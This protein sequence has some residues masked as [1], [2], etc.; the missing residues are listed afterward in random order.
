MAHKPRIASRALTP[1][2]LLRHGDLAAGAGLC[3]SGP[4]EWTGGLCVRIQC[5]WP[6]PRIRPRRRSG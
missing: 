4:L 1:P 6:T 5:R 3:R 2:S